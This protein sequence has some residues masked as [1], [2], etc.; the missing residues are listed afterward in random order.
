MLVNIANRPRDVQNLNHN[1]ITSCSDKNTKWILQVGS[2]T[3]LH[4]FHPVVPLFLV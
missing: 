3:P 4:R 1:K 2:G